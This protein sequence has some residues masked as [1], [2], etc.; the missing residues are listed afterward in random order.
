MP[1]RLKSESR[2]VVWQGQVVI[3]GLR[4]VGNSCLTCSA[5]ERNP[6]IS[7]ILRHRTFV[8]VALLIYLRC[9]SPCTTGKRL[10]IFRDGSALPCRTGEPG[11]GVEARARELAGVSRALA[12]LE[13][14]F[15]QHLDL[16]KRGVLSETEF[17]KANEVARSQSTA[18]EAIREELGSWVEEQRTRVSTADRLPGAIQSFLADFESLDVRHQ[19]AQLQAILKSAYVF[20]DER[21]ELEFRG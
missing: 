11:P 21:I 6:R 18:L 1:G 16:L 10:L 14:Q 7:T 19:K 17:S 12:D 13:G 5:R 9:L 8:G 3:N 2:H 20:R 15:L 4:N